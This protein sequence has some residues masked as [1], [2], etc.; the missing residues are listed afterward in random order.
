MDKYIAEAKLLPNFL[1][2]CYR[3]DLSLGENTL[4]DISKDELKGKWVELSK[5]WT[6]RNP[7]VVLLTFRDGSE[8]IDSYTYGLPSLDKAS[9]FSRVNTRRFKATLY[10]AAAVSGYV[11]RLGVW[12]FEPTIADKLQM[13]ES[14]TEEEASIAEEVGLVDALNRGLVPYSKDWLVSRIYHPVDKYTESVSTSLTTDGLR[15]EIYS[16]SPDQFLVLEA[17]SATDTSAVTV[18]ASVKIKADKREAL[19]IPCPCLSIDYDIPLFIPAL[20]E[21][22]LEFS[23]DTDI[24]AFQARWRVGIYKLTDRIKM[25]WG[26]LGRE[27]NEA[28]WKE[29]K[30]GV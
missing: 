11:C 8:R 24:S 6:T 16:P 3:K 19:Q 26:L 4:I 2:L 25:M 12:V 9:E 30:A 5:V 27:D 14:L 1:V 23:T 18:N 20:D 22:S 10:S 28:L 7:R 21:I 13:G 15:Y 17:I 29:V